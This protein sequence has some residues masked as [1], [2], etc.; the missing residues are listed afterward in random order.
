MSLSVPRSRILGVGRFGHT[1]SHTRP[2]VSW[3]TGSACGDVCAAYLGWNTPFGIGKTLVP[4][5]SG[6][7]DLILMFICRVL[8]WFRLCR[9]AEEGL[10][11]AGLVPVV[12]EAGLGL[13]VR[14][15]PLHPPQ[16]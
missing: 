1:R 3:N 5:N 10:T 7:L 14:V 11:E 4:G 2:F 8:A 16:L 6:V 12:T 13:K 9:V 15:D